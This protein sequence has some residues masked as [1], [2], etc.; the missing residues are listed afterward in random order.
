MIVIGL[1][2]TNGSGKDELSKYLESKGFAHFSA[3]KDI[4]EKELMKKG[5]ALSRENMIAISNELR[6]KD[7]GAISKRLFDLALE[8]GKNSIIESLRSPAEI[9]AVR[10][11]AKEKKVQFIFWGIDANP[12]TRY[13][14][15]MKR[16]TSTDQP[17]TFEQF[18]LQEQLE[19]Q[20]KN[21]KDSNIKKALDMASQVFFNN[22]TLESLYKEVELEL[23]QYS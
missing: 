1:T 8:K 5:L 9:D 6:S 12:R 13:E 10:A 21:P 11:Y 14:R 7:V 23:K 18:M 15:I 19:T 17:M 2:G 4:I 20:S 16:R 22:S 3:R